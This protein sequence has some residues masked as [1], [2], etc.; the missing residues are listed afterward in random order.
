MVIRYMLD[1][2]VCISLIKHQPI[3]V[4]NRLVQF[5]PGEIGISGVVAQSYGSGWPIRKRKNRIVPH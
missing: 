2:N 5:A 4:R 3:G 1:T